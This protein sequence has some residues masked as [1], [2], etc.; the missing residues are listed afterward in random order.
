MGVDF[1]RKITWFLMVNH[2]GKPVRHSIVADVGF[3]YMYT[4]FRTL[5]SKHNFHHMIIKQ[6]KVSL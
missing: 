1:P 3:V 2:C 4:Y 5:F 6:D